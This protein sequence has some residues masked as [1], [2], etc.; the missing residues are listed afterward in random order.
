MLPLFKKGPRNLAENY[1]P[2][3]ILLSISKVMERIMY[4]QFYEYLNANLILSDHQFRFR[5]FHSSASALLDC[6][7]EWYMNMDRK[8]FNLVVF[9]D[10]KK[11]FDTVNN[12]ILVQKLELYGITGN[13]FQ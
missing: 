8:V 6:T 2:I 5:K 12:D 9:L 3:S 4:D 10:S 11:A 13:A 1:R 7:N